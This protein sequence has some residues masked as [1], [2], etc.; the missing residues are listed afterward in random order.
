MWIWIAIGVP[1]GLIALVFV[2]G[3]LLPADYRVR[4][5]V[6]LAL[7]PDQLWARLA[8]IEKHPMAAGM[9]RGV[10]ILPQEN[11]LPVWVEDIGS[12]KIRVHA[13]VM[14][15]PKRVVR[16]MADEIV[17]MTAETE[18]VITPHGEGSRVTVDHA[19]RVDSGTWHVPVFR[20]TL[21]LFSGARRGMEAYFRQF[22]T[23]P[24]GPQ[25]AWQ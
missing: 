15:T 25:F 13:E 20:V 2:V 1:L 18:F 17:P 12:S 14:E 23:S 21:T 3:S 10:E 8:D 9:A 22:A 19:I 16:K 6:D 11:G 7:P 24:A 4:G 5:H